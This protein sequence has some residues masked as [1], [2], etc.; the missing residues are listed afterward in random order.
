MCFVLEKPESPSLGKTLNDTYQVNCS[1]WRLASVR[2]VQE[3]FV[4]RTLIDLKHLQ[5]D[6]Q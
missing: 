1:F 5:T 3:R 6:V 4:L 2:I